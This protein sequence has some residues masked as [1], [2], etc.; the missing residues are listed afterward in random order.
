MCIYLVS[1]NQETEEDNADLGSVGAGR[2]A[3]LTSHILVNSYPTDVS[4]PSPSGF[5]THAY[6]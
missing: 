6:R 3:S 2:I 1:D 4:Y 5:E